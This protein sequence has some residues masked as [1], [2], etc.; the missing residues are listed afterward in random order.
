MVIEL[1][2]IN[3]NM[4]TD[5][6]YYVNNY[7]AIDQARIFAIALASIS[8]LFPLSVVIILIQRYETLV[9]GKSLIHYILM[10]SM[11]DTMVALF[12]AFGYPPSGS[13]A[14]S[15]QGFGLFFFARMSW[16]FTDVLI[17]QLFYV[18]IFKKY[19]LDKRYMHVIVH[20]L[21]MALTLT[22]LI[23]GTRYGANDY[24]GLPPG[25]CVFS[26]G[27]GSPT[28]RIL[29]IE[30]TINVLLYISFIFITILSTIV[31]VYSLTFKNSKSSNIY[32]K[33]RMKDSWKVIVLYPLA[34][35]VAWVPG[36]VYTFF[37]YESIYSGNHPRN[38]YI[39]SIYLITINVLYGP[40]LSLIFYTKTIDAR[41]AWMYNLRCILYLIMHIDID[42]RT[43]CTSIITIEDVRVSEY[44]PSKSPRLFPWN[45][46][47]A[48]TSPIINADHHM[49]P[50]SNETIV[51]IEEL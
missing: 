13:I 10:I 3:I 33:E 6:D 7:P 49:N 19:F 21:N 34:M 29:W 5:D 46:K 8:L 42:D 17:L 45:R 41:R 15:V 31:M 12:F 24:K 38:G 37:Y 18:V 35:L 47:S 32:I 30:Y 36:T 22:P 48:L 26:D 20:T 39:I 14:C 50:M 4:A 40:L 44:T 51:R 2:V 27:M 1:L 43:S 25:I 28:E 11:A 23:K 9:T 16:L